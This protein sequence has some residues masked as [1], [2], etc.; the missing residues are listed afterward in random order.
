MLT[1]NSS[2][3]FSGSGVNINS[4]HARQAFTTGSDVGGYTLTGVLIA[5]TIVAGSTPPTYNVKICEDGGSCSAALTNPSTLSDGRNDW[6]S[7]AGVNLKANTTYWIESHTTTAGTDSMFFRLTDSDAEDSNGLSSWS[8]ANDSQNRAHGVNVWHTEDKAFQIAVF[9]YAKTGPSAPTGLQASPGSAHL[10]LTWTN[11]NNAGISKYQVRV[12]SDGGTTWSPDWTDIAGSGAS[13]TSH[14][15]T[16]LNNGTTYTIEL[17]AVAD[18]GHTPGTSARTSGTPVATA[19]PPPVQQQPV[20]P[21]VFFPP[22]PSVPK[23]RSPSTVD[24]EWTVERDIKSLPAPLNSATGAWGA[25][26]TLWVAQNGDGAADA[27]YAYDRESG[28][29]VEEREFALDARNRAPRGFWGDG[30]TMWIADS[31]RDRLFAYDRESGDRLEERDIALSRRNGAARGIWGSSTAIW[32]LNANPSLFVY[33]RASG[34]L[35]AEYALDARNG[36]PRGIWSDGVTVW[37]SDHGA[38]RLFAYRLPELPAAGEAAPDRPPTLERVRDE[39]FTHL[40]RS[41]NLSPRGLWSDGEVMYVVDAL[42]SHVYTYNM[43]DS[44]DA[45]LASIAL[46]GVEIGEFSPLRTDY[47]GSVAGGASLTTVAVEATQP[48]ATVAVEP[49]DADE[50]ADGHQ[51]ALAGTEAIAVTVTSEDGSRTRVYRVAL[52]EQ[53]WA[54]CLKGAVDEGF[55]LVVSE[56]GSVEELAVC[57]ES[58]GIAALYALHQ[59]SYL[60]YILDAPDFVNRPFAELFADG[61]PALTPLVAASPGPA[62]DDPV[63]EVAPPGDWPACLQGEVSG[64]WSLV[65]YEGGSVGQLAACAGEHALVAAWALHE[66]QW[67]GWIAGAPDFVN[68]AFAELH[69]GGLPPLTPLVVRSEPPPPA[70]GAGGSN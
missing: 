58:R 3:T 36:D 68:E 51:V 6:T 23:G 26:S 40:T 19:P 43:P 9:G 33:D 52:P 61:V 15:V 8:I 22:Q 56:G 2:Q 44:I 24:F 35:I 16:G 48:G 67:V 69:A 66:G 37:V 32:V 54:H 27:V 1:N 20:Q 7:A 57:A 30:E 65:L 39:D 21:P 17:R 14:A 13:T 64:G 38:K 34:E 60:P 10:P 50:T 29:R 53:P 18:G 59:G 49:P 63:G 42:D 5:M 62:S 4:S 28:D 12:S 41:S 70:T 45:R 55:S 47:E 25:G 46:E 11:P 31:G